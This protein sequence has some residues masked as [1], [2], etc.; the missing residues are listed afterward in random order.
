MHSHNLWIALFAA[1]T[2][3]GTSITHADFTDNSQ[4]QLKLRNFYLDRQ[5]SQ[6]DLNKPQDFGSW[7]QGITLDAKSGYLELGKAQVGIDLLAQYTL[8]LSNDRGDNDYI[9]PYDYASKKQARDNFKLGITL[10]AKVNNTELRI[11]EILPMTPVVYFDPSRQLLTTY[12]GI[13][14]ES[15]DLDKTKI[16]LGYLDGINARY[17]NQLH[18][19]KLWPNELNTEKNQIKA[20]DSHGMIVAGVDYQLSPELGLSYFYGD[21]TE[22]YRQHYIGVMYNK[23]LDQHNQLATHVRYFDN[24]ES[25]EALYGQIDSQALSLKAAWTHGSHTLDAGYQQMFGEH[26]SHAP[27]FPT[28]SGWVPQP[29]LANWSVASFIRKDEKSWSL[30]YSYDFK[31]AGVPGLTATVRHYEGWN[32]DNGN[33]T[34]GKEDENNLIIGYTVPEG[35]LKGLGLQWMYIDVNYEQIPGFMDLEEHRIATTYTYKF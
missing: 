3:S 18:D 15:K 1:V 10:K 23:K 28:L 11:G 32:V 31:E 9:M 22:I 5:I 25:G 13:W 4:V 33:G 24:Q 34:R 26:G 30:G 6:P 17:E 19:F 12:Q 29:Y 14:L 2:T 8:R 35:R 27:F 16:T 21:V 7:S 20:G